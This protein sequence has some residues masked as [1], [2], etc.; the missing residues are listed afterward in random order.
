MKVQVKN[1]F[2]YKEEVVILFS[3]KDLEKL[4][5][6][7]RLLIYLKNVSDFVE[8]KIIK[9]LYEYENEL[10]ISLTGIIRK[11]MTKEEFKEIEKSVLEYDVDIID[12]T[13]F[14]D[15]VILNRIIKKI[16]IEL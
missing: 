9:N 3:K 6:L 2:G 15:S 13:D 8:L 5:D 1:I 4:E 14:K 10:K 11:E 12:I 16:S 7:F